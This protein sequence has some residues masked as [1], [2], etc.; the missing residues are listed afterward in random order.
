M[1]SH[2]IPPFN[3]WMRGVAGPWTSSNARLGVDAGMLERLD[4]FVLLTTHW[5]AVIAI[6]GYRSAVPEYSFVLIPAALLLPAAGAAAVTYGILRVRAVVGEGFLLVAD[7]HHCGRTATIDGVDV[8]ILRANHALRAIRVTRGTSMV[9]LR[10]RPASLPAG[11][12][13]SVLS[14]DSCLFCVG[15]ARGRVAD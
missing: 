3:E 10:F 15:H 5:F 4:E 1:K 13:I 12:A 7:Q 9:E 2:P 14:I 6:E 11:A 8:S